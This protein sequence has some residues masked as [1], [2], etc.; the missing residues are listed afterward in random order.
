MADND[1]DKA[2]SNLARLSS[3][4]RHDG[5]DPGLKSQVEAHAD[6]LL[7]ELPA[8]YH[9]YV[10]AVS[11]E[12][13]E[14]PPLKSAAM[15]P[16]SEVQIE[17]A[18]A[19]PIPEEEDLPIELAEESKPKPMMGLRGFAARLPVR[20]Q[21]STTAP[22]VQLF[23]EHNGLVHGATVQVGSS[24][25][26]CRAFRFFDRQ[27]NSHRMRKSPLRQ[28][29]VVAGVCE[30]FNGSG[31][32]VAHWTTAQ[33]LPHMYQSTSQPL[34]NYACKYPRLSTNVSGF[35]IPKGLP[36]RV[37][38]SIKHGS[39]VDIVAPD[40]G[41]PDP[42]FYGSKAGFGGGK[43]G[44]L[45]RVPPLESEAV[46]NPY[47]NRFPTGTS[48][49]VVKTPYLEIFSEPDMPTVIVGMI[50]IFREGEFVEFADHGVVWVTRVS[51]YARGDVNKIW[52]VRRFNLE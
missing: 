2:L 47:Y 25:L 13:A 29:D 8:E 39:K 42:D 37:R 50:S 28:T 36:L 1:I 16:L 23:T 10:R 51:K 14:A 41:V 40:N 45:F 35:Y 43:L 48:G 3:N 32:R 17:P 21:T 46:E 31:K 33:R 38:V 18:E 44:G 11:R 34:P 27:Y 5:A 9:G 20:N 6:T 12:V 22:H 4:C 24:K 52:D 49:F 26:V 19:P 15:E 30:Q 7:R